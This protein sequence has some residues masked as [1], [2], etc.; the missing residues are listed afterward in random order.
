MSEDRAAET[1][2]LQQSG[3]LEQRFFWLGV[4]L[5]VFCC[6]LAVAIFWIGHPTPAQWQI[7]RAFFSLAAGF[8]VWCFRGSL[9]VKTHRWKNATVTACGGFAVFFLVATYLFPEPGQ[10]PTPNGVVLPNWQ[11]SGWRKMW[12]DEFIDEYSQL[13]GSDNPGDRKLGRSWRSV[14][15]HAKGALSPNPTPQDRVLVV[16]DEHARKE[17]WQKHNATIATVDAKKISLEAKLVHDREG[18]A[19]PSAKPITHTRLSSGRWQLAVPELQPGDF[20]WAVLAIKAESGAFPKSASN[21]H[22]NLETN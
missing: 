19:Y 5:V 13:A 6:A 12:A 21:L 18:S 1:L 3:K 9:D 4:F 15:E 17:S 10:T 16:I 11:P 20:I 2:P 7:F 8:A 22:F 14:Y